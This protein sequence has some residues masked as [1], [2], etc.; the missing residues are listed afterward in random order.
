MSSRPR[1]GLGRR[2]ILYIARTA[3]LPVTPCSVVGGGV[4]DS[5]RINV[6]DPIEIGRGVE[7]GSEDERVAVVGAPLKVSD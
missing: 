4:E 5:V 7:V 6:T 1:N 2:Q 3:C